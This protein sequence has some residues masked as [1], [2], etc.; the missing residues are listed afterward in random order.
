MKKAILLLSG[1]LDSAT[2]LSIMQSQDFEVYA[3][4]FSYGQKH[5]Q[6]LEASKKNCC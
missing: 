5:D 2:V 4:S 3:L 1:G 6:E